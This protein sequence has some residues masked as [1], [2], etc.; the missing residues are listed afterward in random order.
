ML[1]SASAIRVLCEAGSNLSKP[2]CPV[3]P[4]TNSKERYS[5]PV[6]WDLH[7]ERHEGNPGQPL[8]DEC[9]RSATVP[10]GRPK[11]WEAEIRP[12][13]GCQRGLP[14]ERAGYWR[15]L[16]RPERVSR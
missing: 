16:Q 5:P 14:G 15:H 13:E 11:D 9:F 6:S 10:G 3:S 4:V 7:N 2:T 12:G 8:D 1:E